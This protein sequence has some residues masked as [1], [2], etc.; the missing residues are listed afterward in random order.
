M[1][2][3]VIYD[4]SE[5]D[6]RNELREYLKDWGG[7]WRQYSVFELDIRE[8]DVEKL[9]RGIRRIVR[10]G[11]G[12]V[13]VVFPCAKCYSKVSHISTRVSDLVDWNIG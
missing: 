10:R 2:V 12:D 9:L 5:D 11:T 13:R 3:F 6:I 8:E 1:K 4:I 7:E